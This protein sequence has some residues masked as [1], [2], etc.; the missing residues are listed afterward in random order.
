MGDRLYSLF[1]ISTVMPI[2]EA[3]LRL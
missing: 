1:S 3:K 2:I